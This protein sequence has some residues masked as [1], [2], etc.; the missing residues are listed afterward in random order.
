MFSLMLL[1]L[2]CVFG[3]GCGHRQRKC[4]SLK[5]PR[6]YVRRLWQ[7]LALSCCMLAWLGL[8]QQYQTGVA[9]VVLL[10][11]LSLIGMLVGLSMAWRPSWCR[12]CLLL[13]GAEVAS[14]R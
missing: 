2:A 3:C 6:R 13:T 12:W 9:C 11:Q 1:W 5:R 4:L 10:G 8:A 14:R 7:V